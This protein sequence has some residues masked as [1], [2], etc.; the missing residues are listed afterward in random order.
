MGKVAH[1]SHLWGCCCLTFWMK[2]D[3]GDMKCEKFCLTMCDLHPMFQAQYIFLHQS[4][5]ELL[6]NKGNSQSIW[7]VSY[8]A[9]EKMDSLDA[10]EGNRHDGHTSAL[11]TTPCSHHPTHTFAFQGTSSWNGRK[12]LCNGWPRENFN[13]F[14]DW[15]ADLDSS[16]MQRR[17][18]ETGS[19]ERTLKGAVHQPAEASLLRF[20]LTPHHFPLL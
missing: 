2:L 12:P 5:L 13:T 19:D 18:W 9:L 14:I 7:F 4:T 6:N 17:W 15:S 20:N 10:M 11:G 8:S 1:L 16:S 3:K